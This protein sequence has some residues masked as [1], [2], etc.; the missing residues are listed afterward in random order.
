MHPQIFTAVSLAHLGLIA[1]LLALQLET[2]S[3][4]SASPLQQLLEQLRTEA[5]ISDSR[6]E[7]SE[8]S[9]GTQPLRAASPPAPSTQVTAQTT[10][11]AEEARR[12]NSPRSI[13]VR[14][15]RRAAQTTAQNTRT[16]GEATFVQPAPPA[17]ME[18][19]AV[20]NT[21]SLRRSQEQNATLPVTSAEPVVDAPRPAETSPTPA[22]RAKRTAE[23]A[24]EKAQDDQITTGTLPPDSFPQPLLTGEQDDQVLPTATTT[25]TPEFALPHREAAGN[26]SEPL[27]LASPLASPALPPAVLPATTPPVLP[28]QAPEQAAASETGSEAAAPDA[29]EQTQQQAQLPRSAPKLAD[30]AT[31]SSILNAVAAGSSGT[32]EMADAVS[33]LLPPGVQSPSVPLQNGRELNWSFDWQGRSQRRLRWLP[34]LQFPARM[35]KGLEEQSI[36]IIFQID[37]EGN[38]VSASFAGPQL[39]AYNWQINSLLLE[40]VGRFL[41]EPSAHSAASSW[42]HKGKMHFRFSRARSIPLPGAA[43]HPSA[44]SVSAQALPPLSGSSASRPAKPPGEIAGGT[45][46]Q[47]PR[48]D[49]VPPAALPGSNP[50]AQ[51]ETKMSQAGEQ[52]GAAGQ[53]NEQN[54]PPAT[55]DTGD[56]HGSG[57]GAQ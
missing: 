19:L 32:Q 1:L 24:A 4:P 30:R 17:S 3:L 15:W 49:S 33:V 39:K 48:S 38:V 7:H 52:R 8:P 18:Q 21:H 6:A 20:G 22:K 45:T 46:E 9:A 27:L 23:S 47:L 43:S 50:S 26:E 12:A 54:S 41:F 53:S 10:A 13:E 51:E 36:E 42:L 2:Q 28:Q 5:R 55:T 16:G 56:E 25:S 37:A 44:G 11:Q 35:L 57:R 40:K 29:P 14:F 31:G 34:S